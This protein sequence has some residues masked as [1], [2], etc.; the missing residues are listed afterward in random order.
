M[1]P[2][3]TWWAAS[4]NVLENQTKKFRFSNVYNMELLTSFEEENNL[5]RGVSGRYIENGMK[6]LEAE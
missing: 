4:F 6:R 2:P 3:G 1:H 5:K